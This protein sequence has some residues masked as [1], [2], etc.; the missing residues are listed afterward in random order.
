M[1]LPLLTLVRRFRS[2]SSIPIAGELLP[3]AAV[4]SAVTHI[5]EPTEDARFYDHRGIDEIALARVLFKTIL[6]GDRSAGGGSTL[7]QQ[8]AKNLFPRNDV[9]ILSMPVNKLREA[10]IAPNC[11]RTYKS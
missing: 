5:S 3:H 2:L 1:N 4:S 7:S 9:G 6:L 10:I 8:I 11:T